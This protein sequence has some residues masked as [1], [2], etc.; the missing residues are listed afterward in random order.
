MSQFRVK[1]AD[2]QTGRTRIE[3]VTADNEA[4]AR[5]MVRGLGIVPKSVDLIQA[6]PPPAMPSPAAPRWEARGVWKSDGAEGTMIIDAA[7]QTAAQIIAGDRG[8]LV[9]SCLPVAD[10]APVP[11]L[12][13]RTPQRE[14][15]PMRGQFGT[16][17]CPVCGSHATP[18]RVP[19][20]S[21]V[22]L[23][24]LLFLWILPGLLYLIFCSGYV[25]K[26]PT[27]GAKLADA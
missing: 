14:F 18:K 11:A 16:R 2:R 23:I 26:C 12:D 24:I 17:Q 21:I 10:A 19:K 13:Y 7:N 9:E 20:G 4:D 22:V 5:E 6:S 3:T 15:D 8:L 25:Y 1:G 27:C